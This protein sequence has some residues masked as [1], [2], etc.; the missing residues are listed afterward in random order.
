MKKTTLTKKQKNV[1]IEHKIYALKNWYVKLKQEIN[2][3]TFIQV[4]VQRYATEL[5]PIL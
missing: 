5:F 2:A 1:I 3:M 4:I